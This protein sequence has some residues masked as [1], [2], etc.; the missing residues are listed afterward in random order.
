MGQVVLAASPKDS[1]DPQ[2]LQLRKSGQQMADEM[3][4]SVSLR[5]VTATQLIAM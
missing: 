3:P 1:P 4:G 5:V 2:R